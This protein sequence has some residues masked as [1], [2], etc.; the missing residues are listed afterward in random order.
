MLGA[1]PARQ[2]GAAP[3]PRNRPSA[4]GDAKAD[5]VYVANL[6]ARLERQVEY[7]RVARLNGIE[8]RVV[9]RI[10][11]AADGRLVQLA[12][13]T[14][15]GNALLDEAALAAARRA[16]PLPPPPASMGATLFY[17]P[18]TFDLTDR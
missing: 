2:P 13:E 18:V 1:P 14:S 5:P 10:G 12:V 9:L 16:A 15:S 7:P 3:A 6:L 4:R 11:V 8:G 17:V